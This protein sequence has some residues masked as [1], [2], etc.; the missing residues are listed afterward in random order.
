MNQLR[1][2]AGLP[3]IINTISRRESSGSIP[4]EEGLF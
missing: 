2:A 4:N 1:G 3:V